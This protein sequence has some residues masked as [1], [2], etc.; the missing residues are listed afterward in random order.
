MEDI[1]K[2]R[3]ITEVR[4]VRNVNENE[5]RK[6]ERE[7]S[8]VDKVVDTGIVENGE[9][10]RGKVEVMSCGKKEVQDDWR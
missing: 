5:E 7:I 8:Q 10:D 3:E 2:L 6:E 9:E 1:D 4:M